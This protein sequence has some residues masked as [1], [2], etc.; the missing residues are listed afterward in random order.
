MF[1]KP[2]LAVAKQALGEHGSRLAT[3]L[4]AMAGCRANLQVF[5]REKSGNACPVNVCLSPSLGGEYARSL[6]V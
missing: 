3:G 2:P 6:G 1:L 4:R 5:C